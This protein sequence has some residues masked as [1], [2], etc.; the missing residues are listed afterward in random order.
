MAL[1]QT[2]GA[3]IKVF[4]RVAVQGMLYCL[5]ANL[6]QYVWYLD[7]L[8][9]LGEICALMIAGL[10]QEEDILQDVRRLKIAWIFIVAGLCRYASSFITLLIRFEKKRKRHKHQMLSMWKFTSPLLIGNMCA[11]VFV[12][13]AQLNAARVIAGIFGIVNEKRSQNQRAIIACSLLLKCLS[14]TFLLRLWNGGKQV[15]V[16]MRSLLGGA[17]KQMLL[18]TLGVFASFSFV[19]LVLNSGSELYVSR[20]FSSSLRG[21]LFG[22]GACFDYYGM[23]I[24]VGIDEP[25]SAAFF[26]VGSFFFNI[27]ILNLIIAVYGSEYNKLEG[28]TMLWFLHGRAQYCTITILTAGFLPWQGRWF[29]RLMFLLAAGMFIAVALLSTL[30]EHLLLA[31]LVLGG[32][33]VLL[34]AATI[35]SEWFSTEGVAAGGED[36][37]LWICHRTNLPME[38]E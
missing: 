17:M 32:G 26:V 30:S 22:D 7:V 5:W 19:F 24:E 11:L 18:I 20:V 6:I 1:A 9:E 14:L 25:Y 36:Q 34:S 12:A 23:N 38:E 15:N 31:A 35:Q 4:R 37:F 3:N 27:L 21:L 8:Y 28:D 10:T 33:E 16:I 2:E 13:L 29:N